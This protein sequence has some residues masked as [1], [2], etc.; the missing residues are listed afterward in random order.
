MCKDSK[1]DT[2]GSLCRHQ[3]VVVVL[4]SAAWMH[5]WVLVFANSSQGSFSGT[6]T[7]FSGVVLAQVSLKWQV[8]LQAKHVAALL[9]VISI[10][11]SL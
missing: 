10:N 5:R 4:F 11:S 2:P 7:L 6:D 8:G 1:L 3:S 9:G